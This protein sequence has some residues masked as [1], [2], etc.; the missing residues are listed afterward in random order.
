MSDKN[1]EKEEEEYVL[2]NLDEVRCHADI[3]PNAPHVLSVSFSTCNFLH[4]IHSYG[5]LCA[6][7]LNTE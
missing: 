2:L 6:N 1:V 3:T 4:R 7:F 5:F